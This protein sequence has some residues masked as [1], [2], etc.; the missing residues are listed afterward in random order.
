MPEQKFI[1]IDIGSAW[2]KVFLVSI[3]TKNTLNLD[4][5]L[6]LP[7]ATHDP[8]LSANLLL[9]ELGKVDAPKIFVSSLKH[10]QEV[11]KSYNAEL[12]KE[13]D[14]TRALLDFFKIPS[15]DLVIFDGGATGLS[16]LA[17]SEVPATGEKLEIKEIG[18]FLPFLIGDINLEN[19]LGNRM[20]FPHIIPKN[21]KEL[22][23]EEAII[24]NLLS[25][26][27]SGKQ[28]KKDKFLLLTGGLLSDTPS[29]N[30]IASL[31]ADCL[32]AP[33][34]VRVLLDRK[35]FLPSF[36]A[37]LT[38][39]KQLKVAVPGPWL[40]I[41]GTFVSLGAPLPVKLD[42][43]YSQEQQI[44]LSANEIVAIPAGQNQKIDL[45]I[46]L[47]KEKKSS[48]I[49]G[50]SLGILFDAREKPLVLTFGQDS[51]IKKVANWKQT[52]DKM[53]SSYGDILSH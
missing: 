5:S 50:G 38:A 40:E 30:R 52:F 36:G 10:A 16:S 37:L 25:P 49:F 6:R 46:T 8:A 21:S 7:T 26:K 13:E 3:D 42:W 53:S 33:E 24:R 47:G 2:T 14:I 4:K 44:E 35:F 43:G 27:I 31:V 28:S 29:I 9:E 15:L 51:S 39:Y 1:T 48:Q 17:S 19:F 34:V 23:I 11:A 12:V 20:H 32:D 41:L 22:D 18:K 45:E